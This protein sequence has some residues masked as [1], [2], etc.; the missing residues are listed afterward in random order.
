VR[1]AAFS[2]GQIGAAAG[3]AFSIQAALVVLLIISGAAN[4]VAPKPEPP[5]RTMSIAVK[6][7]LDL[8]LLKKGGKPRKN[9]P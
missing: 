6:P 2:A 8:P 4:G 1:A 9:T 7:M 5:P 3:L